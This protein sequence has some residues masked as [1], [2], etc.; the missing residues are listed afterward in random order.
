MEKAVSIFPPSFAQQR[1][2]FLDQL[3][4]GDTAYNISAT[5]HLVG[6]LDLAA[7]KQSLNEIVARHEPLRTTFQI[8]DDQ[9]MQVVNQSVTLTVSVRDLCD[10]SPVERETTVR[11]LMSQEARRPFD[12]VKGPLLRV[13]SIQVGKEEYILL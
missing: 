9:L 11:H 4:P 6:E 8:V 1:L 13:A 2:W 7:L 5:F 3:E 10:L 12:L